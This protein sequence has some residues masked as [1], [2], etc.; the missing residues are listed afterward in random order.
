MS[1]LGVPSSQASNSI[2]RYI[3]RTLDFNQI[4]NIAQQVFRF[5]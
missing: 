4:I 1:N 3:A 5:W 2:R